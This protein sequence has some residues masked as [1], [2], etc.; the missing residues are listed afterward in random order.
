[1]VRKRRTTTKK[2]TPV[3]RRR[4]TIKKKGLMGELFSRNE[5]EAGFKQALGVG[6]GFVAAEYSTDFINPNGDK[7]QLEVIVK[8]GG[9]FMASTTARMPNFGA[10]IMA[11]GFKKLL[12]MQ[13]GMKDNR[14]N[15]LNNMS[16]MPKM[17]NTGITL[18][19]DQNNYLNDYYM[20][21][22]YGGYESTEY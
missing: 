18:N 12:S 6:A 21:D 2:R 4:R 10:G 9:G 15:Y 20:N 14:T 11:S 3:K 16:E 22:Y 8:L 5:A 17:I 1:M 19:D 7:D 13:N